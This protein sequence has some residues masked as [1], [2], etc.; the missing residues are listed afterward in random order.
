MEC[1]ILYRN[2][3]GGR[4]GIITDNDADDTAYVFPDRKAA[5]ALARR[6]I[7]TCAWP[8]Q[9]VDLDELLHATLDTPATDSVEPPG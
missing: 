1:V 3:N 7:L 8:Y 4:V 2:P 9:I 6:H 5:M